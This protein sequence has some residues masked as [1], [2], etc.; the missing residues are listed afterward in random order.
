M[1]RNL[2]ALFILLLSSLTI[3]RHSNHIHS[4]SNHVFG[5]SKSSGPSRSLMLALQ[6]KKDDV[7]N[8]L[9]QPRELQMPKPNILSSDM[10]G[11]D[12][13]PQV[14]APRLLI[15]NFPKPTDVN[16]L[17]P[18]RKLL[19][20]T[21]TGV[22]LTVLPA[23]MVN[24]EDA[25]EYENATDPMQIINRQLH[26]DKPRRHRRLNVQPYMNMGPGFMDIGASGVSPM[27]M[28]MN[29]PDLPSLSPFLPRASPPPPIRIQMRDPVSEKVMNSTLTQS[30]QQVS[31]LKRVQLQKQLVDE[32][33][34]LK[35]DM[36][37]KS[38]L[39]VAQFNEIQNIV[40]EI[41][42]HKIDVQTETRA[43]MNTINNPV[44]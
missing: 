6:D 13:S 19:S 15:K 7:L 25:K 11:A 1:N 26:K 18:Q 41:K 23:R 43:L 27:G 12:S 22:P 17:Y 2:Y 16:Y 33:Q 32:I 38:K 20:T 44:S 28:V 31:D 34:T 24:G 21:A 36:Q 39:L 42:Q 29:N 4:K 30:E 37:N 9:Q 8:K 40:Q 14:D 3:Q 35:N 10:I 5:S